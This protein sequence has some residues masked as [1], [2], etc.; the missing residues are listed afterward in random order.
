MPESIDYE[1]VF[2]NLPTPVVLLTPDFAVLACNAAYNRITGRT[3]E[4]LRGENILAAF[5]DNPEDPGATGSNNLTE[6]LRRCLATGEADIMA[7]QRY[8]VEATA[9]SIPSRA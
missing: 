9:S 3:T 1:A 2:Q 4:E 8:D 6:S 5:P 7:L